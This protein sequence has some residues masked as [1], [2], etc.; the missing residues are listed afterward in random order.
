[1]KT[2][3][4]IERQRKF[5]DTGKTR[6]YDFR[7]K[8]LCRLES[9]VK[10]YEKQLIAAL[11]R[12]L[13]KSSF[14][15][16]MTEIGMLYQEIGYLK[17]HLK[18]WM[19]P[20]RVP[21]PLAQFPS[22]CYRIKEPYGVTLIMAPWNYPVLLSLEPMAGAI[23]A[24]NCCV[25]KPSDYAPH[26]AAVMEKVIKDAFP[27]Y[28]V[29]TVLGGRKENECLLEQNFDYIFF[30]GSVEVGKLV[31]KKA[32]KT[33]TPVTLELGGKSPCIVESSADISLA[34]KRIVF[35]KFLNSGQTC[36]APDYI[37]ADQ[38]VE[39]KLIFYLR[40]WI[41]KMIGEQP[42][43]NPDYPAMIN[44]K[45]YQ[46]VMN[47][48]R[49]EKIA[50]GGYGDCVSR[51]IAPT[52][53]IH[54]KEDAPIMQEEIFGPVLP[55]LSY[56][57]LKEAKALIQRRPKPL[58]LYLF[59]KNDKV[60]QEIISHLSY[61]GG[62]VNDTIVHLASSYMGFGGVGHSGMGSYHGKDSFDTF[63]HKKSILKKTGSLDIPVRYM[64]YGQIKERLMR[65]FL[66]F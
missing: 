54:V 63:T 61:G 2:E 42:L 25:L 59:T 20:E 18:G 21:A 27:T 1:M 15:A 14:E 62:C 38:K 13:H 60:E 51:Q 11:H 32:S 53:L 34:A 45:H 35:G 10:K 55:I 29:A 49:H 6:S 57:S 47:L 8:A 24:G 17:K 28:Y 26:T 58:A 12:D 3:F 16:Y 56:Q 4:I 9:S 5:Y 50:E 41:R 43:S 23:A 46:R 65:F 66:K 19:K 36:V 33:L 31:M 64:P 37:L 52:I 48:I 7:R 40:Y 22:K 39:K 44:Q 30:T